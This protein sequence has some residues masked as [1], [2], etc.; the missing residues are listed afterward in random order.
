LPPPAASQDT[1]KKVEPDGDIAGFIG[2]RV[3][4]GDS[5]RILEHTDCIG[6]T[7]AVFRPIRPGLGRIPL[8]GHRVSVC[9]T[10]HTGKPDF[11]TA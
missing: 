11:R 1:T 7:D 2:M 9:I 10:V 4:E 8:E 6:E 3:V 5:T